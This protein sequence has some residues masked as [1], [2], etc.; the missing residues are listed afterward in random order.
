MPHPEPLPAFASLHTHSYY[1][2]LSATP[3]PRDLLTHAPSTGATAMA[4]TDTHSGY[5]LIELTQAA[6]K[7]DHTVQPILGV[8]LALSTDASDSARWERRPGLDGHEGRLVILAQTDTG[9]RH[10]MALI[11][12]AHQQGYFHQPRID[13][14]LLAAHHDGLIFLLSGPQGALGQTL[15]DKGEPAASALLDRLV[16]TVGAERTVCE[17]I[18]RSG[19]AH[20]SLNLWQL[21]QAK[22]RGLQWVV[23]HQARYL[24]PDDQTAADTLWCIG[25]SEVRTAPGRVSPMADYHHKSWPEMCQILSYIDDADLETARRTTLAIADSVTLQLEF[26]QNLLPEYP[27]PD[28][29]TEADELR[30]RC[31]AAIAGRYTQ[32]DI[33]ESDIHQRLDYELSVISRM[34]FD[35]YF[36]ITEDF[37]QYAKD[38]QIA[39]GPGRGSA[40]GSIVAYLLGITNVD[41][42]RY[43][44]LFERFLNPERVSMPDI[45]I[46]FSDERREEVFD[47]VVQK[48][49][50]EKVAKVCTFGTLS[51]KAALKDTGRALGVPF[52]DMNAL[53]KLLPSKPG[54]KLS[55]VPDIE[56][57]MTV[58]SRSPLLQQVYDI[59]CQLEGTVRHVSVHACAVIIGRG[60]LRQTA[61]IQPSPSD[62]TVTITQ[63]P[64][65]QLESLGLLKM[66]F[67]GLRNLS[68]LE[69]TL[70]SITASTGQ[71]IDLET[72]PEQD[73]A[74]FAM[75]SEGETTGVFQFESAGMRRYLKEL[76][77]TEFEDL[78]AMN[79]LYRPGPMEYIPT[80]IEGKHDPTT[81]TYMHPDLEPILAKTYGIAVYQEQVLKIA[82]VFAGFS[83]GQADIL[84]KAIGKKIAEILQ[85]QRAKFIDGA[86]AKGYE[87]SLAVS[88]FDDIVIPFSGYGFNRSHAVCYARIAYETAYLRANYPLQFMQAMMSVDHKNTDRIVMEMHE[89]AQMGIT[90]LPPSLNQ[91]S[92][93]FALA[94]QGPDTV[95]RFGLSAIKGM[96]EDTVATIIAERDRAG[97]F[98]DLADFAARVPAKLINKKTLEA[99]AFSGGLDQFGDRLAIVQSIDD[100]TK[101]AREQQKQADTGQMG[102]FGAAEAPQQIGFTLP[103]AQSTKAQR[104]AWERESLGMYVSDHPLSGLGEIFAEQGTPIGQLGDLTP[105]APHDPLLDG[106]EG[107]SGHSGA[108]DAPPPPPPAKSS[109][110]PVTIHGLVQTS[111]K[112]MTRAGTPMARLTVADLT[113]SVSV[114]VFPRVYA[115][116]TAD[117]LAV[118]QLVRVDGKY[119]TRDEG[120]EVIASDVQ[121]VSVHQLKGE[122]LRPTH[123][124]LTPDAITISI[125]ERTPKATVTELK[126]LL[127]AQRCP[128]GLPCHILVRGQDVL[129]PFVLQMPEATITQ[130]DS[131][132]H[133][134]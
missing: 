53:T 132:L 106:E 112:I 125:P 122:T 4:L 61:P 131:L 119:Q 54:F 35:A 47:Y 18:A 51:A 120:N 5:G 82:Q 45:D 27:V 85:Q 88:L 23:T 93:N 104:L 94:Q 14:E 57:A 72:I 107:S 21:A 31:L 38:H 83:L 121:S 105:K 3:S 63:Y 110:L 126:R 28:G 17:L 37:V 68:I 129:L 87:E 118:D 33:P 113:G 108:E 109:K 78:V 12:A 117:S 67:L 22:A 40:A 50:A 20:Q 41:P 133:Q 11:S 71:T 16:A 6:A 91:S 116:L 60:D 10:L 30:A 99:L 52:T 49:G 62:D 44:L 90:V 95:I 32:T 65:Q 8:E 70:A 115:T 69:R 86:V 58:I 1:S 101:Y 74:T 48:Y 124:Q 15:T 13:F 81:V 36:L 29:R 96:G 76:R 130:I 123:V 24:Q 111:K 100:L 77:P 59:A 56:E 19:P 73:P 103:K 39:V 98:R 42:L 79:A 34:G 46:D 84:R 55:E 97:A 75:M 43:E 114:T 127:I 66:D 9:Y 80:Y 102:L 64:Y 7:L 25:R 89:C 2:L 26:G 128:K 134:S 92:A